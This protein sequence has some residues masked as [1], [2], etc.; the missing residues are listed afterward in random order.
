MVGWTEIGREIQCLSNLCQ[1]FVKCLSYRL[2]YTRFVKSMSKS[3]QDL[4]HNQSSWTEIGHEYPRFVQ[5]LFNR[6][7]QAQQFQNDNLDTFDVE[8]IQGSH[9]LG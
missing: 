8:Q 2:T 6:D 1:T 7:S 4:V 9:M 3:C 5:Q